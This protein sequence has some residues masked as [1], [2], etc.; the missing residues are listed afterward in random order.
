MLL[1]GI[2]ILLMSFID[3]HEKGLPVSTKAEI[4]ADLLCFGNLHIKSING[5]NIFILISF[6]IQQ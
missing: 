3:I 5:L 4:G 2:V 6:K 1:I